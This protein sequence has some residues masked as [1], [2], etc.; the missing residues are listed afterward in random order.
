VIPVILPTTATAAKTQFN[1]QQYDQVMFAV[2]GTLGAGETITP[3]VGTSGG[4]QP[5]HDALGVAVVFD[6]THLQHTLP[7][8]VLYAFD[9]TASAAGAGI[10]AN[11][12][13]Y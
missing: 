8:G 7:G 5:L 13:M 2:S 9:K 11:P 3:F 6:E 10:D 12:R 4:W 1:S